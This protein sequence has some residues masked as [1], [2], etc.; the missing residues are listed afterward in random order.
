MNIIVNMLVKFETHSHNH[1]Q[2]TLSDSCFSSNP[3]AVH[4]YVPASCGLKPRLF[5][6][7][8][9]G[10]FA[11]LCGRLAMAVQP[12]LRGLE[13]TPQTKPRGPSGSTSTAKVSRTLLGLASET[14]GGKR[15]CNRSKLEVSCR[16]AAPQ[17]RRLRT[18]T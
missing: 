11:V 12:T 8:S 16:Q 13:K 9:V 10:F 6:R 4:R 1:S 17:T 18:M 14:F 7:L 15:S 3:I 2:I 5:Q